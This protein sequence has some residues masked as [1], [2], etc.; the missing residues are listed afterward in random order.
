[1]PRY[2][3]QPDIAV[4]MRLS[5]ERMAVLEMPILDDIM[6]HGVLGPKYR[7]GVEHGRVEGKAEPVK[8]T[9]EKRFDALAEVG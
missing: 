9:V 7:E 1:M 6:D 2:K 4:L 8:Q 5:D 3:S